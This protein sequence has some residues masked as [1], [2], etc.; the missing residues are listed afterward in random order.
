MILEGMRVEIDEAI[1]AT[2]LRDGVERAD[3]HFVGAV[4]AWCEENGPKLGPA[5]HLMLS[6]TKVYL[7]GGGARWVRRADLMLDAAAAQQSDDKLLLR[8]AVVV[9]ATIMIG[10][11]DAA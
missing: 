5:H 7:D 3:A 8:G 11:G 1:A 9:D 10:G 6:P 2:S 4:Q